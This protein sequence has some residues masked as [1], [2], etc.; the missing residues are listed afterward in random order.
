MSASVSG[1]PKSRGAG[2]EIYLE[3]SRH[4]LISTADLD[5]E[6]GGLGAVA[7]AGGARNGSLS[8]VVPDSG[9]AED[10]FSLL[11]DKVL[12]REDGLGDGVLVGACAAL[13]AVVTRF[14]A[15]EDEEVCAVGADYIHKSVQCSFQLRSWLG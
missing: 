10:V 15:G 14:H 11:A 8:G 4:G 6:E 3:E 13:E 5:L 7:G 12:A 2:E 1:C 9:A